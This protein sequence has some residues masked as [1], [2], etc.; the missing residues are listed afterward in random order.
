MMPTLAHFSVPMPLCVALCDHCAKQRQAT[1]PIGGPDLVL[2]RSV[3]WDGRAGVEVQPTVLS[4]FCHDCGGGWCLCN[5]RLPCDNCPRRNS[6]VVL[7][8]L[9]V[10]AISVPPAPPTL[11]TL[12]GA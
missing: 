8:G 6:P 11:P 5:G 7:G 10:Y 1:S 9:S 4:G 12:G 2:L 3:S